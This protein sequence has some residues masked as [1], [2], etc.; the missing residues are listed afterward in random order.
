LLTALHVAV[1]LSP[2][3]IVEASDTAWVT[4]LSV[5]LMEL[6]AVHGFAVQARVA[7]STPK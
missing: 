6:P 3:L 4:A 7:D 1:V 2:E 5:T